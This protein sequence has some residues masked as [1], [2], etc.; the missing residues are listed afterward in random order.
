M[1]LGLT[2]LLAEM[3]TRNIFRV[4][5]GRCLE[6]TTLLNSCVDCLEIWGLNLWNLQGL[7][8]QVIVMLYFYMLGLRADMEA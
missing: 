4:K 7:S 8:R 6:L 3:I 5:G 1:A 2:Q